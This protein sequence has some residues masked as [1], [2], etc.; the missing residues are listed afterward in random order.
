MRQS[1]YLGAIAIQIMV[2]VEDSEVDYQY[3]I[4]A[5]DGTEEPR[6]YY[7]NSIDTD[8]EAF[9]KFDPQFEVDKEGKGEVEN[10]TVIIPYA[11]IISIVRQRKPD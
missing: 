4:Q 11:R 7:A 5:D 8:H 3:Q 9:V 2:E 1:Y 10:Q 6:F